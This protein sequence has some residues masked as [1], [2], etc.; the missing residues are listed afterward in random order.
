MVVNMTFETNFSLSGQIIKIELLNNHNTIIAFLPTYILDDFGSME[1]FAIYSEE[2][3]IELF[4]Q[5]K[6][7]IVDKI[8]EKF[9]KYGNNII[10]L[11]A[12]DFST[13]KINSSY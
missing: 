13:K 10:Y 12:Y 3:Y 11:I 9:S 7:R 2:I 1:E 5:N 4:H 8:L 6:K